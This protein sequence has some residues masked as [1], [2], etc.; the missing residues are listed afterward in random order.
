MTMSPPVI[1]RSITEGI[2][3]DQSCSNIVSNT[4]RFLLDGG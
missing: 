1:K 4:I 2:I 3:F